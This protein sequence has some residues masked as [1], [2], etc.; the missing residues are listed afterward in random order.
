MFI[1]WFDRLRIGKKLFFTYVV[2]SALAMTL[3]LALVSGLSFYRNWK[4]IRDSVHTEIHALND[5]LTAGLLFQDAEFTQRMLSALRHLPY[6]AATAIYDAHGNLVAAP[7]L[8]FAELAVPNPPPMPPRWTATFD[9]TDQVH[10]TWRYITFWHALMMPDRSP[11]GYLY[12]R[13]D[14][15]PMY[16]QGLYFL[17]FIL[18]AFTLAAMLQFLLFRHLQRRVTRPLNALARLTLAIADS[19]DY[20]RRI[21]VSSQDEIGWLGQCFNRM[22][23]QI[24]QRTRALQSHEQHLEDLVAERTAELVRQTQAVQALM[25]NFPFYVWIK[26]LD[27]RYLF[28]NQAFALACERENAAIVGKTDAELWPEKLALRYRADDLEVIRERRQK[29]TKVQWSGALGGSRVMEVWIAPILN[30]AGAAQG[31][32]GF[33]HDITERERTE[34]IL[35]EAEVKYRTVA[36][37]TN[38]WETWVDEDGD[39]CYI[40]PSCERITGYQAAEFLTDAHLVLNIVHPDDRDAMAAHFASAGESGPITL[41]FRIRHRDGG[42]R[43]IEHICQAVYDGDRYLGRRASNRDITH[44]VLTEQRLRE[45]EESYHSLFESIGDAVFVHPDGAEPFTDCNQS[46][47]TL[48]G[49]ASKAELLAQNPATLSPPLQPGGENSMERI[50]RDVEC[51]L[52]HGTHQFEWTCARKD[53][54]EFPANITL[55]PTYYGGRR[56]VVAIV[57]DVSEHKQVEQAREQA[58]RE[59]QRLAQARSEFLANT[60]HEIR[61]P[62]NAIIGL[63]HLCLKTNLPPKQRDY[64]KKIH[65]AALSL[66]SI[67]ND[68]LD[69]SKIEAGKLVLEHT[70]FN[71]ADLFDD[72]AG[73]I[74]FEAQ[75]KGLELVLNLAPDLPHSLLGDPLRLKQIL[76][77]L[78][79]NAVKF[80]HQGEVELRCE[81]VDQ[82]P[83]KA[84]LYFSVRD[85]GIGMTPEQIQRIFESFNQGDAS[86]T[87]QFGGTGLGLTISKCLVQLMGAAI[88]VH[89]E[90][91]LGSTFSFTLHFDTD[92]QAT[93]YTALSTVLRDKRVLLVDSNHAVLGSLTRMLTRL[94]LQVSSA[95]SV[96]RALQILSDDGRATPFD[97][98]L[99][100]RQPAAVAVEQIVQQIR[101][102]E[103]EEHRLCVIL[104]EEDGV[105]SSEAGVSGADAVLT[106]PVTPSTLYDGIA[107][108]FGIQVDPRASLVA[109]I[110]EEALTRRL[111]GT[112]ILLVEDHVFSQQVAQELLEQYGMVVAVAE[113]GLVALEKLKNQ[114]FEAVLMDLQM[115]LMDGYA[116]TREIRKQPRYAALPIIAMTADVRPED[117]LLCLA[118]GMNDHLGKPIDPADLLRVLAR[119]VAAPGS[120]QAKA[121][122]HAAKTA[123]FLPPLA[124]ID[125]KQGL[126]RMGND[127]DRYRRLLRLFHREH[128]ALPQMLRAR[129]TQGDMAGAHR[130]AHSLKGA[131]GTIGAYDLQAAAHELELSLAQPAGADIEPS[132]LTVE[133]Q[134]AVVLNALAHLQAPSAPVAAA[135]GDPQLQQALDELERLLKESN[136]KAGQQMDRILSLDVDGEVRA[137]LEVVAALVQSFRFRQAA[138]ALTQYRSIWQSGEKL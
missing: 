42:E 131:A 50:Q 64:V 125:T 77:N 35:R 81:L 93:D 29:I 69:Y 48:F 12:L 11:A 135:A 91:N 9:D 97:L 119:W 106:K 138:E 136:F 34:Q 82:Q 87:R 134:L 73:L 49:Y 58:L 24:E 65:H 84:G 114:A 14:L 23:E 39:Y 110:G 66:L 1:Q 137:W 25:D 57:R 41:S 8:A 38:D 63:S 44:R 132:L 36:E 6:I 59:S 122:L 33:S 124:G 75:E 17:P 129:L 46:A 22:L 90:L 89:S 20:T 16:W 7:G 28:V 53:G 4:D 71:V 52:T 70:L 92:A 80:T 85:T 21:T 95:D 108:L 102:Y 101:A 5:G 107:P 60:S 54:S 68:I 78:L 45:R 32:A 3:L 118:A 120:A 103:N 123:A 111:V 15:A 100:D 30:K 40:S 18:V 113:N 10:T 62:M 98:V 55:S 130:L 43:W 133:S 76:L 51:A 31:T 115:P 94:G 72:L 74:A 116:T 26:D 67:I 105:P 117:H 112:H 99:L 61:T 47:V 128:L 79:S 37:F 127:L 96:E 104:L 83:G 109:D 56:A 121:K 88:E 19:E 126:Y 2:S 27:S 13:A 86:T